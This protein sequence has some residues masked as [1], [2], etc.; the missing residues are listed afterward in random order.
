MMAKAHAEAILNSSPA[1]RQ[2]LLF[3][4]AVPAA[5]GGGL[6]VRCAPHGLYAVQR[7]H[8]LLSFFQRHT[9]QGSGQAVCHAGVRAQ[10]GDAVVV[11]SGPQGVRVDDVVVALAVHHKVALVVAAIPIPNP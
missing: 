11:G 10:H 6:L 8:Q 3:Q 4:V 5:G 7:F 9:E 2:S 1:K